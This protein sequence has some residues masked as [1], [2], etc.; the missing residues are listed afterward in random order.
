[1]ASN[2]TVQMEGT[3]ACFRV[4]LN[5]SGKESK[6]GENITIG[7]LSGRIPGFVHPDTGQPV[8]FTLSA[9]TQNPNYTPDPAAIQAKAQ[10]AFDRTMAKY[11]R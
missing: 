7:T 1:M 8:K 3:V 10:A 2:V 6:S 5:E 11:K 4:D 9:F